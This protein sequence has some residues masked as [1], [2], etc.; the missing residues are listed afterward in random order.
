[1]DWTFIPLNEKTPE[2]T[3]RGTNR[4]AYLGTSTGENDMNEDRRLTIYSNNGS[5]MKV[6]FPV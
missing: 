6:P 2:H 3:G 4:A 1:V 5:K